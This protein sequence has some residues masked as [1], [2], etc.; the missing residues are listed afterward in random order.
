M[1]LDDDF[2]VE[3]KAY[4][5][6]LKLVRKTD[7]INPKTDK[8]VVNRDE[9]HYPSLRMALKKY[10]DESLKKSKTID[11]IL[12]RLDEIEDKINRLTVK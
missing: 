9:W 11:A 3:G 2:S 8:P 5:W 7:Q 4:E 6:T 1:K 12:V 10:L